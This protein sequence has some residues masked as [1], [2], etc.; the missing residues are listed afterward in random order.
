MSRL[1]SL[2][3]ALQRKLLPIALLPT[4]LMLPLVVGAMLWWGDYVYDKLLIAKVRSDLAVARGYFQQVVE[5]VASGTRGV[6]ASQALLERIRR[7]QPGELDWFLE[8]QRRRLE[9]DFLVVLPEPLPHAPAEGARPG[10]VALWDA[11]QLRAIAPALHA[12]AFPPTAP[13]VADDAAAGAPGP[14]ALVAATQAEITAEGRRVAS[15]VGGILLN[16]NL[17]LVDRINSIVYPE[18]ALPLGSHGT[19]TL[20]LGDVRVSTNVRLFPDRRAIGTRASPEVRE[21]V[22]EQGRTWLDRAYVVDAWYMSGYEALTDPA[23]RRVGMLYVGYLE[24]PFRLAKWGILGLTSLIFAAGTLLT[25]LFSLARV[26]ERTRELADANRSLQQ[27]QRQLVQ[28]EKLAAIG[29]VTAAL[30]HEIN[31]PIAV[32]QGNLDLVRELLQDQADVVAPELKLLDQQVERMRAMVS[33][34]LQS[35]RPSDYAVSVE[36]LDLGAALDESLALSAPVLG[37]GIRVVRDY[38]A[39]RLVEFNRQELQQLLV[40]LIANAVQAM[41]QGGTLTLR[42]RDWGSPGERCGALAEVQDTGAGVPP[43]IRDQLFLPQFTTRR[44]GNGLG[45]WI[46]HTLVE[47][48]GGAIEVENAPGGG[49]VFRVRLL[50]GDKLSPSPRQD[51]GQE[52][53][54]SA[55]PE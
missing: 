42:T 28:S 34:L 29:Q 32:M 38:R 9:L 54:G 22:L 14:Y 45:L 21:A 1:A 12:R 33:Q 51:G 26:A 24:E 31:N 30:A 43:E 49:A 8:Q 55:A 46:S 6:A 48:R 47:R 44:E 39:R 19:S 13:A 50:A 25:V 35:A 7:Q 52:A 36:H 20:F 16:Q 41:P 18:G 17:D 15:L 37:D 5:R 11:Q 53:A 3:R 4:V 27:A 40:N 23:G 10:A 2:R